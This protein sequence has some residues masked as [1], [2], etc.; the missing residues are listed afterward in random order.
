[1]QTLGGEIDEDIP[2]TEPS[3]SV[4][5]E[6]ESFSIVSSDEVHGQKVGGGDMKKPEEIS[7]AEDD[8]DIITAHVVIER[9]LHIPLVRTDENKR[10]VIL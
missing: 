2:S 1:M 3:E 7:S 8:N 10:F 6:N 4:L 9:A 5:L